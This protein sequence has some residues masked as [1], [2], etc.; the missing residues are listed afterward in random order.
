[1]EDSSI[2]VL[3]VRTRLLLQT[4]PTDN[5]INLFFSSSLSLRQNKLEHYSLCSF[6]IYIS[7]LRVWIVKYN[8]L[9]FASKDGF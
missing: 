5:P 2:S 9:C 4:N 7:S 8:L 6:L 3:D 1:V